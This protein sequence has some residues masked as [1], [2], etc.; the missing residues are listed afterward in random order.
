MS[1]LALLLILGAA[2]GYSVLDM[3]RKLLTRGLSSLAVLLWM[4]LGAAPFFAA[5]V[6]IQSDWQLRSGY[7]FPVVVAISLQLV[8]NLAFIEAVRRSPLSV[9]IPLLSLTPVFTAIAAIPAL[10]EWP[11][12]W[13]GVGIMIVVA[14][15]WWLA[16]SST[17]EDQ[18][19]RGFWATLKSEPGVPL[20]TLTA[21]TWA[22]AG[23]LDKVAMQQLSSSGGELGKVA[24]H[25]LVMNL[26]VAIG[27]LVILL[28]RGE[29]RQAFR[30]RGSVGLVIASAIAGSAALAFQLSAMQITLVAL[31]ETVK[32]GINTILALG[33]GALVFRERLTLPKLL[34]CGLMVAGVALILLT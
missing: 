8:A 18:E 33:L 31:V 16:R 26:G 2:V 15:A 23:T 9:T 19:N 7:W 32:R 28:S 25:G 17:G 24:M 1:T 6:A 11:S 4:T 5:W 12:L 29:T 22:V 27:T 21:I 13:E 30:I 10:R 34:A 3:L 14:G 20:M